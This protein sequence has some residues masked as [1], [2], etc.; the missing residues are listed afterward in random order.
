MDDTERQKPLTLIFCHDHFIIKTSNHILVCQTHSAFN[1]WFKRQLHCDDGL[2]LRESFN[3][4]D[5]REKGG[6]LNASGLVIDKSCIRV[7]M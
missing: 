1:V 2:Q 4:E 5:C 6:F 3:Y 7:I